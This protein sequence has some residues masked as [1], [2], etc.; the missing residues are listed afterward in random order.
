MSRYISAAVW[1]MTR[2]SMGLEQVRAAPLQNC[3]KLM[4]LR[5][6]AKQRHHRGGRL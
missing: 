1:A 6:A 5:L 3:V 4:H 2:V